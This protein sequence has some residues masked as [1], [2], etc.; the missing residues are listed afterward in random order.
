M[1]RRPYRYAV[2]TEDGVEECTSRAAARARA[3]AWVNSPDRTRPRVAHV[4]TS[5]SDADGWRTADSIASPEL[6]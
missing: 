4:L 2:E 3:N 6:I 5:S 1:A